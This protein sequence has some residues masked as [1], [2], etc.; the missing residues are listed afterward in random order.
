MLVD[1]VH[2]NIE[3]TIMRK[4]I[5]NEILVER[6]RKKLIPPSDYIVPVTVY[7]YYRQVLALREFNINTS[8]L[9]RTLLDFFLAYPKEY[10]DIM[11]KMDFY[12]KL[13]NKYKMKYDE[14]TLMN[15]E[16]IHKLYRVKQILKQIEEEAISLNINEKYV[17]IWRKIK[18][19]ENVLNR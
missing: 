1:F 8:K 16:L 9:I 2:D 15:K 11:A 19:L 4:F 14:L 5:N 3:N 10:K 13:F 12:Y 7:L 18:E 6:S 17:N